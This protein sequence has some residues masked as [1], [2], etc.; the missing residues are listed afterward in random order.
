M[1]A[2]V[3]AVLVVLLAAAPALGQASPGAAPITLE[4]LEQLAL[5]NN[6]TTTAAAAGS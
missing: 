6:P 1:T 2:V 4:E 3:P 5:Q